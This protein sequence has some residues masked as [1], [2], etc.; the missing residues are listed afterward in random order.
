MIENFHFIRP[1]WFLACIPVAI[2]IFVLLRHKT[3]SQNW[4]NFCDK[5]LLEHLSVRSGIKQK[6]YPI[7]FL[8]LAWFITIFALAGPSWQ[9]IETP[10]FS[11]KNSLVIVLDLS[12]SMNAQDLKPS[13]LS[14]AR[15]KLTDILSQRVEGQTALIVYSGDSH[16]VSPLT[17]DS[18]TI[19]SM[20]PILNSNLMPV[21]GSNLTLAI[22]SAIDL[23]KNAGEQTGNI[24]LFTDGIDPNNY[25]RVLDTAKKARQSGYKLSIIGVGSNDGAPIP[26]PEKG[27]YLKDSQGNIFVSRLE[28]QKLTELARVGGGKYHRISVSDRDIEAVLKHSKTNQ[29]D[30][31]EENPEQQFKQDKWQDEGV[32][33]VFILIPIALLAFRRGWLL[34]LFVFILPIPQ[35][36]YAL[37]WDDLWLRADQQGQKAFK[38][39]LHEQAAKKFKDNNWQGSA[40]YKAG[41]YDKALE[42]FSRSNDIES[43]YN[44]G[45]TLAQLN[46]FDEALEAYQE[47]LKKNPKHKDSLKNKGII[48]K[49]KEQQNKSDQQRG[50][51]S[52]D[53][54]DSQQGDQPNEQKDSK[55]GDQSNEQEDS[56]QGDKQ[57]EQNQQSTQQN[58][59]KQQQNSNDQSE[60]H[61]QEKSSQQ[62]ESQ[63]NSENDQQQSKNIEQDE[64]S[65]EN[66]KEENQPINTQFSKLSEEEQQSM[67]QYLQ[68]IPDD[69]SYLLKRKFYLNSR[70]NPQQ[71]QETTPW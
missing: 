62:K 58:E 64:D 43:I 13:R 18:K 53:Q 20:V 44:K 39:G 70:R 19:L 51:N 48:E 31:I 61:E 4:V 71:Q 46:R 67:K 66:N 37:S 2:A 8:A 57:Q 23:F 47:V 45:N 38:Q 5:V 35:T 14:R 50:D 25:Q 27:G 69:P 21:P 30:K 60:Q 12:Q 11:S 32:Y 65:D 3:Y 49:I 42:A 10:L 56:E 55:Q 34:L 16:I 36:S 33:L 26:S 15:H 41:Q 9:K 28:T 59:N 63:N 68:Q 22:S 40:Y 7:L 24:L 52:K 1:F 54:K 29:Y 17:A 6:Q